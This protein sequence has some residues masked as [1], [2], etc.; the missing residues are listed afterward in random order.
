VLD[1]ALF[2][3][4]PGLGIVDAARALTVLVPAEGV[5]AR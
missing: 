4:N 3:S 2:Q 1:P 5:A